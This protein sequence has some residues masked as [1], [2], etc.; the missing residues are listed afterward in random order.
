M[1]THMLY[2]V[3]FVAGPCFHLILNLSPQFSTHQLSLDDMICDGVVQVLEAVQSFVL[4]PRLILGVREYHAKLMADSD[5]ATGMTS[6]AFQERVHIST[7][8]GV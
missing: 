4:G 8:S 1:K 5:A 2:F 6:I 3:S 7:G